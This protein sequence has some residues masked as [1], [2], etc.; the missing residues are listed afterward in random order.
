MYVFLIHTADN[1]V[2]GVIMTILCTEIYS[3]EI[4]VFYGKTMF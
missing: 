2:L 4:R 3:L 1:A